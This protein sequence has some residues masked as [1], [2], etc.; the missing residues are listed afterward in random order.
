MHLC[1][2]KADKGALTACSC[3]IMVLAVTWRACWLSARP[4]TDQWLSAAAEDGVT[5]DSSLLSL[6]VGGDVILWSFPVQQFAEQLN[7][8]KPNRCSL[9]CCNPN[10]TACC[11]SC[12][13][14]CLCPQ[15][16]CSL[17]LHEHEASLTSL[18]LAVG[19]SRSRA[20]AWQP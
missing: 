7:G 4:R 16:A 3:P 18:M 9:C 10:C 20:P 14:C 1:P 8:A 2:T 13:A 15:V 12:P 19:T 11:T 17:R 6:D 5:A